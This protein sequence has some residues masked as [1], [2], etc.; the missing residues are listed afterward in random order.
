MNIDE[1]QAAL[2][3]RQAKDLFGLVGKTALVTGGSRGLGLMIA[4]GLV[5]AGVRVYIS[6]RKAEVCASV[7]VEL[8]KM[9]ECIS[10]PEDLAT[11]AGARRL[12]RTIRERESALYILVNNAGATWGAPL[13]DYP[14]SAF[15]KLW[16]TNV[17]APFRLTTEL[18]PVL[19][20]AATADDPAR[21]VN[22]GSV[23]AT[24]VSSAGNAF[25]YGQ[26]K[27]A[28]HHMTRQLAHQL[29]KAPITV[30]A[31]AP[32]PF[33]SKMMAYV[34]D[35]PERRR[36]VEE[37]IPL[38]RIGRPADIAGATIFLCSR[39]GAFLTGAILPIDGGLSSGTAR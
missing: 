5:R 23:G 12:A 14:E 32:G 36:E 8:S 39:A 26:T 11:D 30:N 10:V 9:G 22:I 21:V 4:E 1:D 13:E 34:L 28:L 3:V 33:E 16:A 18:L 17:K 15:D 2:A 20:A 24:N 27:A 7:A 38:G 35:V 31:L 37:G 19:R 29:S 6:S 25:A